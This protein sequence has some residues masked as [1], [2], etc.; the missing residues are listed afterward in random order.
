MKCKGM[1]VTKKNTFIVMLTI[2][3]LL[4]LLLLLR[5][6]VLEENKIVQNHYT[7]GATY[8]SL[9]NPFFEELNTSIREIIEANGDELIV[10][11][12]TQDQEKQNEE[13]FAMIDQG[14]DLLFLSPIDGKKVQ[15]ALLACQAKGIP[16]VNIDTAVNDTSKVASIITS[17]NYK[18]GVLIAK[19]ILHK[20][21]KARIVLLS[22]DDVL[23]TFQRANG[24]IDTLKDQDNF[25]IIYSSFAEDLMMFR[26]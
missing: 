17:N 2:L 4:L 5:H 26:V 11:N 8:M 1:G 24:F 9:D 22:H 10:R 3:L 12:P 25:T 20:N 15:P 14:I 6:F 7:F 13:I 21:N 16:V 18:A 19:D 23:S